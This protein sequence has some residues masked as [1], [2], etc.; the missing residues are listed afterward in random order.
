[1]TSSSSMVSE[2]LKDHNQC[3]SRGRKGGQKNLSNTSKRGKANA[4]LKRLKIEKEKQQQ[5]PPPTTN[6]PP[7]KQKSMLPYS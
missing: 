2:I 4:W 5:N 1:M 6:H 3:P 7:N